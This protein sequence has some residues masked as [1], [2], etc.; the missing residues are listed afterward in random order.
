MPVDDSKAW[1]SNGEQTI[2]FLDPDTKPSSMFANKEQFFYFFKEINEAYNC[3]DDCSSLTCH[4]GGYK[5]LVNGNCKCRCPEGLDASNNCRTLRNTG[6][7]KDVIK[8]CRKKINN[9]PNYCSTDVGPSNCRKSCNFCD[10]HQ[11]LKSGYSAAEA[12]CNDQ[13][14]PSTLLAE[15]KGN[16]DFVTELIKTEQIRTNVSIVHIPAALIYETFEGLVLLTE[17]SSNTV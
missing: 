13:P 10:N 6:V 7:C 5:A 9:N 11:P 15:Y 12:F 14:I 8:T 3:T 17:L 4:N 2:S 16:H 1:S